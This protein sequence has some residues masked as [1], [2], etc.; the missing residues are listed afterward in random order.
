MRRG[1]IFILMAVAV[2]ALVACQSTTV[3]DPAELKQQVEEAEA[4]YWQTMLAGDYDKLPSLY[5][6]DAV[7]MPHGNDKMGVDEMVERQN[8]GKEMGM[9][10]N[11]YTPTVLDV[12]DCGDMVYEV[13]TYEMETSMEGMP[14]SKTDH[15]SYMCTWK[16][17]EDG[18]LK[19]KY[20]IWN[21]AVVEMPAEAPVAS[22]EGNWDLVS[23]KGNY[24]VEG[25]PVSMDA[26]KDADNFDM[27]LIHDGYFMFT[28]QHVMEG[29]IA[30][31]YGYGTYTY[32]NNVYTEK[33]IY[34]VA[35]EFI[36]TTL[37]YEMTVE[38]DTLIQKGPLEEDSGMQFVE[39]YLR[40]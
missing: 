17:G 6:D 33:L 16:K 29:E 39:T 22:I 11:S 28:G 38:G 9:K 2:L 34:H 7:L 5:T 1:I 26:V 19:R 4:S 3:E 36:G 40:K 21:S 37:S 15:G 27:K 8:Q 25:K 20:F 24:S 32:D 18:S 35:K 10:V 31:A 23:V 30:P 13:G 14:M 12:W